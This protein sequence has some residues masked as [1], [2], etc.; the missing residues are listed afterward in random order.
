[1]TKT[2]KYLYIALGTLATAIGIIGMF[3]PVLPTTP[4]LM[5]AAFLYA[6]SSDRFL[7]WLLTNKLC[8]SYIDNYRSGRG[9]TL[10]QKIGTLALLWVT[11]GSSAIFFVDKLWIR[12][13]MGVVA[14]AVTTHLLMLPTYKPQP[15]D[16]TALAE[17]A[18]GVVGP[19]KN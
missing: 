1:M 15:E 10:R 3:L 9:I 8:G 18:T 11:I 14:I 13:L 7:N 4:F 17:Q 2:K 5:L 6:R 16:K 19:E 12:I